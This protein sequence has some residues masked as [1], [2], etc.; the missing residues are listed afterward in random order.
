M[1]VTEDLADA[2]AK[3]TIEAAEATGDERLI[4]EVAKQLGA[5]SQTTQEAYMTAVRV[6]LA[7]KRARS[8][9]QDKLKDYLASQ[10]AQKG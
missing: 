10:K 8:F 5:S 3:D 9:L 6:R 1:G 7:E 2:L 4:D